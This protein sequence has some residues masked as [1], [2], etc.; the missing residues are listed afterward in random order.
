[1]RQ[2]YV[3][4]ITNRRNGTLY[5]GVTSDILKR[6]WEHKQGIVDGF[7]QK[8]SLKLLVWYEVHSEIEEAIKREKQIKKWNR[9]WKL[10]MIEEVNPFWKDLY[11][12]L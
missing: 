7:S 5:T 8:H 9:K 3:Y 6:I 10:R 4:I 2:S 12:E 11:N 1:V